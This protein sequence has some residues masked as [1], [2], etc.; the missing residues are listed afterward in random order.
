MSPEAVFDEN[1]ITHYQQFLNRRRAARP[2][3]EYREP[4]SEERAGFQEHFDKRRVELGSC[5]R[6]YGTPC[7]HEHACIRCPMLSVNS[8]MLS[9]L[10]ELEEDLLDR[11]RRAITEGWQGEA[12]GL[13]LTLTFLRSKR[14]QTQRMQ[15]AGTVT[16]GLPGQRSVTNAPG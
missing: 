15:R 5:G 2:D 3:G 7:A 1:V 16:L 4:T 6:P 10:D 12:K 13:N 14:N 9:R 8:T 11:R